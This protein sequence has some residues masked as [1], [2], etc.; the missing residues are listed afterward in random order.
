MLKCIVDSSQGFECAREQVPHLNGV[1]GRDTLRLQG[2]SKCGGGF[3][4]LPDGFEADAD[5]RHGPEREGCILGGKGKLLQGIFMHADL[6]ERQAT[7]VRLCRV[8][9]RLM[10]CWSGLR[11]GV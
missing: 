6:F 4:R 5:L 7:L 2:F 9:V 8:T 10:G 11:G 3:L 1:G